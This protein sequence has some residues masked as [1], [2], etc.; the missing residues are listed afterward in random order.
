MTTKFLVQNK[1]FG[2]YGNINS[3]GYWFLPC[4]IKSICG[5]WHLI[6]DDGYIKDT[7][8]SSTGKDRF[9][10]EHI[11]NILHAEKI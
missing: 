2:H 9:R 10:K 11:I 4:Q 5:S 6:F 7:N 3:K 8:H 1:D